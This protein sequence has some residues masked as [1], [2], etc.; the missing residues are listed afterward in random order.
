MK[1]T[2]FKCFSIIFYIYLINIIFVFPWTVSFKINYLHVI[3]ELYRNNC[4]SLRGLENAETLALQ[5]V[6]A[7][8]EISRSPKL[9]LI[10]SITQ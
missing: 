1:G 4:G 2:E 6:F 7:C 5:A 9:Q 10:F 3:I 8:I